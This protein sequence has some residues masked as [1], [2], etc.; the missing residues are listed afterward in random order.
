MPMI[1]T[2]R[3]YVMFSNPLPGDRCVAVFILPPYGPRRMLTAEPIERFDTALSWAVRMADYM[4]HP[5][6]IDTMP[7]RDDYFKRLAIATGFEGFLGRTDFDERL[8]G[9]DLLT[10]IGVL[11]IKDGVLEEYHA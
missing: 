6:A 8:A 10:S 3:N 2:E 5:I 1:N 9:L 4:A 7:S 11:Q